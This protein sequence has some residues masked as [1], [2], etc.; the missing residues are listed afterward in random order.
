LD[1]AVMLLNDGVNYYYQKYWPG[2]GEFYKYTVKLNLMSGDTVKA[3]EIQV[4]IDDLNR[5]RSKQKKLSE[6]IVEN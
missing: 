2:L 6:N 1:E 4:I 5:W 3:K